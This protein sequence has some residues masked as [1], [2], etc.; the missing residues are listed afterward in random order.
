MCSKTTQDLFLAF[1]FTVLML[2]FYRSFSS[3]YRAT[4]NLYVSLNS[5][6]SKAVHVAHAL[7][8]IMFNETQEFY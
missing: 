7:R 2:A 3:N 4:R 8:G 5:T 1:G 6:G